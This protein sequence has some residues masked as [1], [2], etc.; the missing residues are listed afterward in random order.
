VVLILPVRTNKAGR[1]IK[2]A[3]PA[4]NNTRVREKAGMRG[5]K[6]R[7]KTSYVKWKFSKSN[8]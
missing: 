4:G 1:I 5:T 8:K 7:K 3:I 2:K 6:I